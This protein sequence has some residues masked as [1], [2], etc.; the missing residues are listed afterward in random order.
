MCV[1]YQPFNKTCSWFL[2]IYV[3]K[4][5][6]IQIFK[7]VSKFIYV[8]CFFYILNISFIYIKISTFYLQDS[9]FLLVFLPSLAHPTQHVFNTS[10]VMCT[11]CGTHLFDSC[12]VF[13]RGFHSMKKHPPLFTKVPLYK[14]QSF[15]FYKYHTQ[16]HHLFHKKFC[17]AVFAHINTEPSHLCK[18]Q[19]FCFTSK[20]KWIPTVCVTNHLV[21]HIS[22]NKT[23]YLYIY[24][25]QHSNWRTT[26]LSFSVCT[27]LSP[28]NTHFFMQN[29]CICT[30]C[31]TTL[32]HK[33]SFFSRQF[34][35]IEEKH[36]LQRLLPKYR[37][38]FRNHTLFWRKGKTTSKRTKQTKNERY[39]T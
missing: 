38:C 21:R 20:C 6:Y 5:I 11:C 29:T 9:N 30:C 25:F 36:C 4:Y 28:H 7:Y 8:S 16:K 2:H 34:H 31:G 26:V 24:I 37:L 23:I 35:G 39:R 32:F 17:C 3:C 10:V 27:F 18:F 14:V 13:S 15:L 22:K 12:T 1:C 33:G 19:S